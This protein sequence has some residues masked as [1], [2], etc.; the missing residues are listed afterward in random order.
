M[1]RPPS[2]RALIS[3]LAH[4]I[5]A[6]STQVP[7]TVVPNPFNHHPRRLATCAHQPLGGSSVRLI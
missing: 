4:P 6:Y 7:T 5:S 2:S 3:K 1:V